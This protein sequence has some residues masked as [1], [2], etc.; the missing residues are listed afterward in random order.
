MATE[1]QVWITADDGQR[2]AADLFLPEGPG[3]FAALLEA[4]PYRKDDLTVSYRAT[5]ARYVAAGF[6]VM[7]LDLRGT[8]S[9]TGLATDEYPEVERSDLGCAIE[10]LASRPWSNGRVG[11]FGTSYS[12]FNSLHMAT[13]GI[14]ALGAVVA[15]YATDDR[16]TDDVHYCGGVLRALDLIDYPLYMVAMNALPPVPA[17]FGAD[18]GRGGE[19]VTWRDEWRRRLEETPAW[20]TEWLT[21][22]VDGP[23]WRRGSIRLGPDGLGY[24]RISCPVMLIAGWADGYRNNTFRVIEQYQ[25][26]GLSG[27]RLLAGPW[28]HKSPE[29]ARPGPNII[30]DTEIIAFF[31]EHLGGGPAAGGFPA[32][33]Y[34]RRP[35]EPEPDL[36]HHPGRWVGFVHWPPPELKWLALE[37]ST[38]VDT[39]RSD[40]VGAAV[41]RLV[42]RGDVGVAAWNSCG[43]GLPWGQPLDQR[44]D[45]ARSLVYDWDHSAVA[46]A[47]GSGGDRADR[48]DR[49]E[50]MGQAR[51]RMSVRSDQPYGHLG[52]KLCD[53]FP[54]GTSALITRGMLDLT[55]L[56]CWPADHNGSVSEVPQPLEPG[57]WYE[58]EIELEATTWTLEPG[59]R[60]RLA[61]AG[62]DWP[63]CWPPPGPLT[64]EIDRASLAI[65]LP[66]VEG[67]P[68]AGHG[69]EPGAG[70]RSDEAEGVVWRV[71]HD[72]LARETTVTTRY[73]DRYEGRHGAVISEDY[74]GQLG[75]S[76]IDPGRAW[77]RGTATFEVAWPEVRVRT[78]SRLDIRS[79]RESFEV[80]LELRAA[81]LHPPTKVADPDSPDAADTDAV[82]REVAHRVWELSLPRRVPTENQ[83]A[84]RS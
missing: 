7:R 10:W 46:V 3:P 57:R 47:T 24:E 15:T 70:P 55:H 14:P 38:S 4:L 41:D 33:V 63:N 36:E 54:D 49:V 22:P 74:Q 5:Y 35:V 53:V 43:G 73:G 9:S 67:L 21:N 20:L 45:N 29:R 51:V 8:G 6:A 80:V 17:V 18:A 25:R 59:H 81:E 34:V 28:V 71:E 42:V 82:E 60:L 50:I 78:R 52:V 19:P 75:V 69:F 39:G 65:D 16:Y 11:M 76:T 26:N 31:D 40:N 79:D 12:G 2:L 83:A 44:H 48:A 27:W 23:T 62:T 1:Q 64:L 66:V 77:A 56:G 32:T 58:V 68:D 72:V 84:G 30:D 37:P 61:V 13:E